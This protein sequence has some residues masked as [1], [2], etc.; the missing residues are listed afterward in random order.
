M[1]NELPSSVQFFLDRY[2]YLHKN[3]QAHTLAG[4]SR[5]LETAWIRNSFLS[6]EEEQFLRQLCSSE[7]WTTQLTKRQ[8]ISIRKYIKSAPSAILC[9]PEPCSHKPLNATEHTVYRINRPKCCSST[10]RQNPES[11]D[12]SCNL[13][14]N[15]HTISRRTPE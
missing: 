7:S 5:E 8:G 1:R 3:N 15:I 4:K 9:R 2:S 14:Q 6:P 12:E 10:A 13:H 11:K